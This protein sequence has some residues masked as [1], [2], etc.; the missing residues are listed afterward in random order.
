MVLVLSSQLWPSIC[1]MAADVVVTMLLL[2]MRGCCYTTEAAGQ[3]RRRRIWLC[4]LRTEKEMST[5]LEV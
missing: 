5:L 1:C 4:V 2:C 3:R